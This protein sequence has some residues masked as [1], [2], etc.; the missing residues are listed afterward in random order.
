MD[1][2]EMDRATARLGPAVDVLPPRMLVVPVAGLD[3]LA[4]T[5]AQATAGIGEP[6]RKRFVGHLTLARVKADVPM[7]PT[8]GA[9]VSAEFDVDEVAL[10]QSRLDPGGARYETPAHLERWLTASRTSGPIRFVAA[11]Y[12]AGVADPA[13]ESG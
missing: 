1:D 3:D 2:L 7:P 11:Q 8:L 10:V 12:R 13:L 9:P 6:P 4:A 5:I